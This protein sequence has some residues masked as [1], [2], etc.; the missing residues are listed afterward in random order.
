MSQEISLDPFTA[1]LDM[2]MY[3]VTATH[4]VT[5]E[6]AGCLVGF[7]SQC[8]IDPDRF[9]VW[10]SEH[11]HTYRVANQAETLAVHGLGQGQR[12][13]AT[14]FG[15]HTGDEVDKFARCRWRPGPLGLPI[16]TECPRWF[17]GRILDRARWGNHTGFLLAPVTAAGEPEPRPLLFSAVKDLSAGHAAS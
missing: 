5:G 1:G 2:P 7:A 14:L 6:R 10:L 3:I 9:V 13:L 8:A 12:E 4:P 11:N 16:L 15:T 17:V